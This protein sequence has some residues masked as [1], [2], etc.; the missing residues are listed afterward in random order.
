[1]QSGKHQRSFKTHSG[2]PVISIFVNHYNK[3]LIS[4]DVEGQL[5]IS[6]FYSGDVL[7]KR[8]MADAGE[9]IRGAN[10][11]HHFAISKSNFQIEMID[12]IQFVSG[13]NFVGHEK[14]ITDFCFSHDNKYIL[15][16]SLDKTIKVWDIM[17]NE[18]ML[19]IVLD[20]IV[21]SIDVSSD[22]ELVATSFANS[23]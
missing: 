19:E 3:Y 8:I 18:M 1:L 6:D 7:N 12:M 13:R 4:I 9:L 22:G 23:R 17:N 5:V 15:S 10:N 20:K 2:A 16:A 21:V 14:K 11:S